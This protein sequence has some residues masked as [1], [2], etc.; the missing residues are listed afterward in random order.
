MITCEPDDLGIAADIDAALSTGGDLAKGLASRRSQ[1][2]GLSVLL[3][4]QSSEPCLPE[5]TLMTAKT[6]AMAS[7]TFGA[8]MLIVHVY[9]S[10]SLQQTEPVW[11]SQCFAHA[12]FDVE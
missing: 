3:P 1:R 5:H 9:Q 4:L 2:L 8:A 10:I 7:A 6:N 12:A 11:G